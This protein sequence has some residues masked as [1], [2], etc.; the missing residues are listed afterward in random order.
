M[1]T[2]APKTFVYQIT[3]YIYI[4]S[5]RDKCGI[6]VVTKKEGQL[7]VWR[8]NYNYCIIIIIIISIPRNCAGW[9]TSIHTPGWNHQFRLQSMSVTI[10]IA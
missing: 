1:H 6:A 3:D 10:Q 7:D 8:D 4:I 5:M 9:P 2:P